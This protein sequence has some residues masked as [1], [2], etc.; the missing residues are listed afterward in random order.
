MT[1]H[2]LQL[3][4]HDRMN[5]NRFEVVVTSYDRNK[6]RDGKIKNQEKVN[7]SPSYRFAA[8]KKPIARK[9]IFFQTLLS[10]SALNFERKI[11]RTKTT[12]FFAPLPVSA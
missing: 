3:K 12:R 1:L 6:N 5:K 4:L 2:A 7:N 11:S 8:I 9:R 10:H